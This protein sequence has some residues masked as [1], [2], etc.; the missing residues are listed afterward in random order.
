MPRNEQELDEA[1][2]RAKA[3]MEVEGFTFTKKDEAR[4]KDV[5]RGVKSKAQI[6]DEMKK[7]YHSS[8][9]EAL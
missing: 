3:N 7:E 6:L 8:S 4:I 2:R 1:F 5:L 9:G